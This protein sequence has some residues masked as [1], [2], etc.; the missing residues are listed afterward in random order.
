MNRMNF[1]VLNICKNTLKELKTR[2]SVSIGGS[3]CA[4]Y[5]PKISKK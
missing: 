4:E 2:N 5:C 1:P 3:V